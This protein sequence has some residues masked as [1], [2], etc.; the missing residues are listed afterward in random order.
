MKAVFPLY[1][2]CWCVPFPVGQ[3]ALSSRETT[4]YYL[5]GHHYSHV[6]RGNIRTVFVDQMLVLHPFH[7]STTAVLTVLSD[8]LLLKRF[9]SLKNIQKYYMLIEKTVYKIAIWIGLI[10]FFFSSF[11]YCWYVLILYSQCNELVFCCE[12]L[13]PL[14]NL[15]IFE[16]TFSC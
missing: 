5:C 11:I 14:A 2:Y 6:P 7:H 3:Q 10:G 15:I 4:T 13:T 12:V 8:D 1:F 16:Q 9:H